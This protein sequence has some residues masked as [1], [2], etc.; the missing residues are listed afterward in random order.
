MMA[1]RAMPN[2]LNGSRWLNRY[3]RYRIRARAVIRNTG[4]SVRDMQAG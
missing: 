1:S 3:D 4:W 2:D